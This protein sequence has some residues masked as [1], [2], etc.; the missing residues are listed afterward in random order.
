MF[1]PAKLLEYVAVVRRNDDNV[2]GEPIG[3]LQWS[4][5]WVEEPRLIAKQ[6]TK[7]QYGLGEATFALMPEV[8]I[9]NGLR[10][11]GNDVIVGSYVG[12]ATK[13]DTGEISEPFWTGYITSIPQ[14]KMK[15]QPVSSTGIVKALRLGNM[16]DQL[17]LKDWATNKA[18]GLNFTD[19]PP[20]G[21]YATQSGDIIGNRAAGEIAF[22][23]ESDPAQCGTDTTYLTGNYWTRFDLLNHII[24][25]CYPDGAGIPNLNFTD[26][27]RD[28]LQTVVKE[29]YTL[30]NAT[31][32]SVL[33]LLCNRQR[34]LTWDVETVGDLWQINIRLTFDTD[35]QIDVDF[36][37]INRDNVI[38]LKI[39]EGDA[40]Q[41]DEIVVEGNP[42]IW[43]GTIENGTSDQDGIPL[44]FEKAWTIGQ[45]AAYTAY[46]DA[47]DLAPNN[48]RYDDVFKNWRFVPN[49]N[50]SISTQHNANGQGGDVFFCQKISYDI[51]ANTV[52]VNDQDDTFP[53]LPTARVMRTM[54]WSVGLSEAIDD[55]DSTQK[56]QQ[57]LVNPIVT[58]ETEGKRRDIS[59]KTVIGENIYVDDRGLGIRIKLDG[60]R[61]N[62]YALQEHAG[63]EP[64][65]IY[66]WQS[67]SFT[68]AFESTQRASLRS[69]RPVDGGTLDPGLV[70]KTLRIRGDWNVWACHQASIIGI[71]QNGDLLRTTTGGG[72]VINVLDS[73]KTFLLRNDF[74][75]IKKALEEAELYHFRKGVTGSFTLNNVN[76]HDDWPIAT[77]INTIIDTDDFDS[78]K[79][80]LGTPIEAIHV[81]EGMVE[82][83]TVNLDV[84]NPQMTVSFGVKEQPN[85]AGKSSSIQISSSSKQVLSD[86]SKRIEK[87]EREQQQI[88]ISM[89]KGGGAAVVQDIYQ[90]VDGQLLPPDNF[91]GIEFVDSTVALIIDDPTVPSTS[92]SAGMGRAQNL[93]T[94]AFVMIVHDSDAPYG[95]QPALL[96]GN[97]GTLVDSRSVTV[98]QDTTVYF[99]LGRF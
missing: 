93:T 72:Y 12:I 74:L 51:N 37:E 45:E 10:V 98:G 89:A 62:A 32:K 30:E 11:E 84:G 42:I 49:F 63:K 36:A 19:N 77:S 2:N 54:P 15:Q 92:R 87:L 66:S 78:N 50:G 76:L 1:V 56:N 52:S 20:P 6:Y 94:G 75:E 40:D 26:G 85:L 16:F 8:F 64:V 99:Y 88:P 57:T 46:V 79:T 80:V 69:Y 70:R 58:V 86:T 28:R 39:D 4:G 95:D 43:M 9:D 53:Y 5:T 25:Y 90:I 14:I 97:Y 61:D 60:D 18:T 24:T 33:D 35:E 3:G 71:D 65:P 44:Y 38:E 67:L 83:I 13:D 22:V 34:G 48:T 55:R 81:V 29:V 23:F 17:Q 27:A 47:N 59:K 41:W 82:S 91:N 21:N 31:M 68:V 96:Q 7:L 73:N